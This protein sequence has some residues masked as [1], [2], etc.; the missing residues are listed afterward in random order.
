[1]FRASEQV[2]LRCRVEGSTR[3]LLSVGGERYSVGAD[4]SAELYAYGVL[5]AKSDSSVTATAEDASTFT[6]AFPAGTDLSAFSLGTHVKLHCVRIAG[7]WQMSYM[8]SET[9]VVEVRH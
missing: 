6:C 9:A 4:G 5:T 1:M 8:K 2:R 7:V 3:T